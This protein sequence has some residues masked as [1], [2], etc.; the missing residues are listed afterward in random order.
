M[1]FIPTF[2]NNMNK[3]SIAFLLSLIMLRNNV[4][5][6]VEPTSAFHH[7]E[8]KLLH[9]PFLK[10]VSKKGNLRIVSGSRDTINKRKQSLFCNTS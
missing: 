8:L 5:A 9:L 10:K 7:K 3:I 2:S 6:L 1:L 4:I